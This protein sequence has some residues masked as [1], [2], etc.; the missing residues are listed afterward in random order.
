M[1]GVV[2][3]ILLI[4]A[5]VECMS[6]PAVSLNFNTLLHMLQEPNTE[7]YVDRT[8]RGGPSPNDFKLMVLTNQHS[9]YASLKEQFFSKWEKP[10]CG[11]RVDRIFKVQV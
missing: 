8:F 2:L 10:D 7:P 6:W 9:A 5:H 4:E 3:T 11:L 1:T